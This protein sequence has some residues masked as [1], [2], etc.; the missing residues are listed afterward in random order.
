ME[1]GLHSMAEIE[2][3]FRANPI[4]GNQQLRAWKRQDFTRFLEQTVEVLHKREDNSFS[5]LLLQL[6]REDWAG[7]QTILFSQDLMNLDEAARA[8]C[9]V[10][11]TDPSFQ[12]HLVSEVLRKLEES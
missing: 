8:I 3:E 1:T 10:S 9:V 12:M 2:R 11:K 4:A 5:Q 6:L 7:M